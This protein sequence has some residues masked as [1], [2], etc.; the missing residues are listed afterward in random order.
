[1]RQL[2]LPLLLW[3]CYLSV[4]AAQTNNTVQLTAQEQA[5]LKQNP[6]VLV[7]GS[8]DWTPF[9]FTD[10]QGNY[11]GIANDYLTLIAANTGLKYRVISDT[12]DAN[13]ARIKAGEIHILGAVYKTPEREAY[14]NFSK[15]YFEALDYFFVHQSLDV[16]TLQ[17]LDGKKLAIPKDYAHRQILKKHFPNIVLVDADSFGHAID[18]V[19]EREADILFDTYG[20]LI[21]TL[22]IEGISTIIPFKSTRHLGKNPIHIVSLKTQPE[23]ATI[24][25]K[26]LDAISEQQHRAIYNKWFKSG[27][28]DDINT[29]I[30]ADANKLDL[31][32]EQLAWIAKH[33][34]I[35]ISGDYAWAPFEFRNNQGVYDGLSRDLLEEIARLTGLNFHYR[36]D[37]WE[38]ALRQVKTKNRD[39][40]AA[41]FKTP[42]REQDLL[43]TKSY[44]SLLNSFFVHES[45]K[46]SELKSLSGKRLAIIRNSAREQEILKLIPDLSLVYVESPEQAVDAILSD[47]ADMLYDSS[48]VV[49]Y[50]IEQRRIEKV[51]PFKSLPNSPVM[52]LHIA[53]RN[54]YQP[55]VGILNKAIIYLENNNLDQL[56]DKWLSK[57]SVVASA[58][59]I[60]LTQ[61]EK[62]WLREN[63]SLSIVGD[64]NWMPF[65]ALD[66]D[67]SYVGIIHDYLSIFSE[68]LNIEFVKK[69]TQSWQESE[70]QILDGKADIVAAFPNYQPF[71]HLTYTRSYISSPVVFVMQNEHRYI[72]DINQLLNRRITLLKDYPS[73]KAIVKRF[74]SKAFN[75]VNSPEQGLDDLSSGKT[76]VFISSLAQ[77]NYH[78]AEQGYAGL[79]VVGKT[80]YTLNI[81]FAMQPNLAPL[82]PILDKVLA[83]INTAEKQQILD[84]WGDKELLVKTDYKLV[85]I[86]FVIALLIISFVFIWNRKLQTEIILRK[87]IEF[88]LKQ[89]ERNL[90][91]VIDNTPVIIYV[92]NPVSN[93]L[94]MANRNAIKELAIREEEI[95][96]IDAS[97]FYQGDV[98][99]I[100]GKQL[101]LKTLDG[102]TIDGQLSIIPIRYQGQ[103]A[104]LHIVVNLNERIAMEREL[105]IQKDNAESANK[106][107]S[108]FLANMSHEI[109]TPM[110]AI[111]GFTEL[112][113]EQVQDNK[114]KSFVKTIK[115]AGNSLLLLINDILDLSKIEAGKLTISK[116]VCNP[117]SIFEDVSNIFTMN[118]KNKGLDFMLEVD[119][120]IPNALLLDATRI[121]QILFNLVGNAVKFTDSGCITLRA[122]A[123]N[124]NTIHSTVDLKIDVEDTGIGIDEDK[125]ASIFE[126]FQQQEGQSVRKYGGTGL[127]L[128][129]SRRLTELM[130]GKIS[131]VSTPNKGSC[132]SVYLR[133]IDVAVLEQAPVNNSNI[134]DNKQVKFD[135]KNIL[136]VDDIED[137]RNL[138]AEIFRSLNMNF[139]QA[140]NG[141]EAVELAK[142]HDFDLIVMDIR[143]PQMDGY[144]AANII[145]KAKPDL[146]IVALTASVMRDDYERSRREN[147]SGY[148]RK[149]V[150]KQELV[151]ELRRHLRHAEVKTPVQEQGE[152]LSISPK[153][154][155]LLNSDFRAQCEQLKLSNNL[156]DIASFANA[157]KACAHQHHS[158]DLSNFADELIQA[159]DIFDIVAIKASLTKF[160]LLCAS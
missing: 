67:Q 34:E 124:E 81:S 30:A 68:A 60:N 89:S 51:K 39:V 58:R 16:K 2:L 45:I 33:P 145:K 117:H 74:P 31:T 64:P 9:N 146:P 22:D 102:R 156:T 107:K 72:E 122:T 10:R 108:E 135:Q 118:V 139:Q 155:E 52:P 93:K 42:E 87:Q 120:H 14:L 144:Q 153:L 121:R 129:I 148:L 63:N 77:A 149:P 41:A 95:A 106:A 8:L 49:N 151:N 24:I 85:A 154:K 78:I 88:S 136:I 126:S 92:V 37:V 36:T 54:D 29:Q 79:R 158:K 57:G 70:S 61:Q 17:D 1:M 75:F 38:N 96:S 56:V 11:R 159:T 109:R 69:P 132:F 55:L 32:A 119:E 66:G 152:M 73:T 114:L 18:L 133:E 35:K 86:V 140:S 21:Y 160:E 53:V 47:K 141:L 4:A 84:H 115:S 20:A 112:L 90:S 131:V 50:I 3:L 46:A 116:E 7:G 80:D 111:I 76:D 15:P 27:K 99:A 125:I 101:Q 40:L 23:L 91:V 5:W 128:T 142:T 25:Q 127:G 13:L 150:L 103:T 134:A 6:E 28:L 12:W 48:A 19:L 71:S 143:M 105:A 123:L 137:N 138:L 104:L 113:Y 83:N 157:L 94:V 59:N 100:S 43:F 147:F 110:N 62:A 98:N 97:S 82:A 44:V 130:N 65:E 26:G